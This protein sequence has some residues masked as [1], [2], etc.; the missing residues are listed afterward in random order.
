MS[1]LRE[2]LA[3]NESMRRASD[4]RRLRLAE[5]VVAVRERAQMLLEEADAAAEPTAP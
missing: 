2:H 3:A 4:F 5:Q 1:A